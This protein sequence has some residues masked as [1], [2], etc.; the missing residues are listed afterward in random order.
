MQVELRQVIGKFWDRK[1]NK[2]RRV[3]WDMDIL[4][5]N[6]KQIAT[7]N[8]TPGAAIGLMSHAQLTLSELVA[9][10]NAVAAARGGVK[11]C[12]I[13]TPVKMPYELLDD[14]DDELVIPAT[15]VM[16]DGADDE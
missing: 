3:A 5:L 10:E 14:E 11:P 7:I 16:D 8:R 6:G 4:L 2:H 9:V 13:N 1:A 15:L 12:A